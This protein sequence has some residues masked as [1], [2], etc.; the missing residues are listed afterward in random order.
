MTA[1]GYIVQSIAWA[2][3]GFL[4]GFL[5]GRASRDVHAIARAATDQGGPMATSRRRRFRIDPQAGIAIVVV[6]LGVI[7]LIQAIVQSRATERLDRCQAEYAEQFAQ[8]LDSRALAGDEAWVAL[9]NLMSTVGRALD[10]DD[11]AGGE[12]TERAIHDYIASRETMVAER[13]ANPIAPPPQGIC[14]T[15]R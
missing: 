9:D 15:D 1:L 5:V 8:A 4:V 6:L 2:A 12:Q 3:L 10:A 11:D 13:T 14:N 7:T